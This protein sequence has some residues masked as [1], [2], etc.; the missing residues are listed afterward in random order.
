M[1]AIPGLGVLLRYELRRVVRAPIVWVLLALLLVAGT[2]GTV[3]TAK[4]HRDQAADLTRMAHQESVWYADVEAR[5]I[6][7]AQ[8]SSES[9]PYW[10]DPTGASGFSRYFLKRFAAKPH[11]PLSV[12]AVG[13]SD[14]QPF[15]VPVRLETLFGGD[16]VYD[17]EPPRALATGFFDLGFVLVF[18]LPLCVGAVAA[19]VGAQERDDGILALVA[20]QPVSPVRWWAARLG[21]LAA[22]LVP[23]TVL[24]AIVALVVAGA[25]IVTAW[26][27][28]LATMVLVGAHVLLWLA[29]AAACLVRGQGAVGTASTVTAVW[30]A[31]TLVVP[32]TGAL[33]VRLLFPPPS[34][35]ADVSE[36]RRTVDAV[37]RE[38]D[39][40][41][42]R[43]LMATLG[44]SAQA[45]DPT[46]LDYSTR[47]VLITPEMEDRLATQEERRRAH[48]QSA[49]TVASLLAWLSPQ[50]AFQ[51]ALTDVA[52]TGM[53]RHARFL[54]AVRAYQLELRNFMYPRVL[55]PAYATAHRV[56]DD[57]PGRL[58][59]TDYAAIPRFTMPEPSV[60][61]HR[62]AALSTAAWFLLL[63]A[64]ITGA[65]L[66]RATWA[67]V[68]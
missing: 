64:V 57:C 68:S 56:C 65:S 41:V 61:S 5:A 35:I 45:I 54:E 28:T 66:G 26:P 9:V 16:R 11:L 29:V 17:F 1:T 63:A 44:P 31:L 21:A 24:G 39:A 25:P 14:V 67:I 40:V 48:M 2:W 15:A 8:P 18:V 42:A 60:E 62:M 49:G 13:Q 55:R 36:L 51:T 3:N 6:R 7:Y 10:Q 22:V 33:A 38:A 27:E 58:T 52:G 19:A 32:L 53:A 47:L 30:L 12:L 23:G 20:A 4:L 34:P 46:A 50:L 59:F 43:R 37:Q